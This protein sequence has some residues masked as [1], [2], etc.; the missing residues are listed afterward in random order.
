MI[1]RFL[2]E[3]NICAPNHLTMDV[4]MTS[5]FWQMNHVHPIPPLNLKTN[6]IYCN[7]T[8]DGFQWMTH[9]RSC[10]LCA[11]SVGYGDVYLNPM[12]FNHMDF[13]RQLIELHVT[14][15]LS[16]IYSRRPIKTV[17]GA[18]DEWRRTCGHCN[19]RTNSRVII[20]S[21]SK[22]VTVHQ[23]VNSNTWE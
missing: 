10:R 11:F 21:N 3:D 15:Q 12:S 6:T 5:K 16:H 23:N 13:W 14:T 7:H 1:I 18:R 20:F 9:N 8:F 17:G 4:K 22:V 19:L 2:L